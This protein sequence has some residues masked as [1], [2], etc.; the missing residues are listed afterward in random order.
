[1]KYLVL[2]RHP[3]LT[4]RVCRALGVITLP[5]RL[6]LHPMAE[7]AMAA[8]YALRGRSVIYR[9]RVGQITHAGGDAYYADVVCTG[10]VVVAGTVRAGTITVDPDVMP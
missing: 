9:A 4:W 1:M 6:R 5:R 3:I 10:I 8:V 2:V 7:R